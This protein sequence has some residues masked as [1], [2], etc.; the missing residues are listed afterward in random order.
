[1]ACQPLSLFLLWMDEILHHLES[2]LCWYLQG[3]HPSRVSEVVQD[4]VHPQY[5][6][7]K[8]MDEHGNL[9]TVHFGILQGLQDRLPI[10]GLRKMHTTRGPSPIGYAVLRMNAKMN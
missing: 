9:A 7:V 5:V 6:G 1:M 8:W 3:N 2:I 4:F 10:R